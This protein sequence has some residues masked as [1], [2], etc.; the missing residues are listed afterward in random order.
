M[1]SDALAIADETARSCV[2]YFLFPA[3]FLFCDR[4]ASISFFL[5]VDD[6]GHFA[7]PPKRN[8]RKREDEEDEEAAEQQVWCSCP[9]FP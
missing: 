3:R 9:T 5:T 8:K 4:Y 2:V 7:M 1:V 6:V